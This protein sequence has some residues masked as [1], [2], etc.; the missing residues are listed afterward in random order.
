ME[1]KYYEIYVHCSI[2]TLIKRDTKGLYFA[3]RKKIIKNLIGY[4][5]SVKY[6]KSRYLKIGINTDKYNLSKCIQSI[7][8]G[9]N[10]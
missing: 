5:S 6:Q 1:K 8:K 7:M 4:N 10:L 9:I 3:A 2:R